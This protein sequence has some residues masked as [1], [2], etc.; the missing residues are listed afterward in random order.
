MQ[1]KYKFF[2]NNFSRESF[3]AAFAKTYFKKTYNNSHK[4]NRYNQKLDLKRA[5]YSLNSLLEIPS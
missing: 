5:T 1:R 4:E 2:L 3:Y